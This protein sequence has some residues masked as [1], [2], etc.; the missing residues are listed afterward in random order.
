MRA[1]PNLEIIFIQYN[2]LYLNQHDKDSCC[3]IAS[4]VSYRNKS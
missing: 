1:Q 2:R 3:N 4:I